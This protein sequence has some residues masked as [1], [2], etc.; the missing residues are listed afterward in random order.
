MSVFGTTKLPH[1]IVLTLGNK[2]VHVF[3]ESMFDFRV[4]FTL[5]E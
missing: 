4:N 1:A 5:W 3:R 2:V